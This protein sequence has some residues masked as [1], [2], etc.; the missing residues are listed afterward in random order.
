MPA[1]YPD[2]VLSGALL[3]DWQR[4]PPHHAAKK[5]ESSERKEPVVVNVE[6]KSD[7]ALARKNGSHSL[8]QAYPGVRSI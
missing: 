3:L 6:E 4:E 1:S 5:P 8:Q 2:Q 7:H